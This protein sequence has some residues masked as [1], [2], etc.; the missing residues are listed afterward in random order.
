[1]FDKMKNIEF[2]YN[3]IAEIDGKNSNMLM[4]V[5]V[6]K[7]KQGE[8]LELEDKNKETAI[9]MLDGEVEI[10]WLGNTET[11]KRSSLFDEEP[12]CLHVPK[13]VKVLLRAEKESEVLVQKTENE[14][15]FESKLY[16]PEDCGTEI[17]GD[18]VWGNTSRRMVR[19]IFDYNNAPCS[20]LVMGEVINTPGKWSS[21]IPHSHP[22]PE[23][24][25]Y[26]FT[27][28]Q[29]FG[30]CFIG[31]DVFKITHN[32]AASIPGGLSHPQVTA[33]GYGMYYCWM[34]RHLDGNPWTDRVN[35]EQHE[36]L[37]EPDVK[38]WPEK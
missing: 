20:N 38:I 17:F 15:N 6:Y 32:S 8:K 3:S 34:I 5:G 18:D 10:E 23:I 37:L 11:M 27:K 28:P 13:T 16:T 35:E 22:Q 12:W 19:T 21:Y 4:D 30:A 2:G 1:M 33:P 14:K 29:G 9:L 36:W 31:D 7:L 26:R 25:F 24:Y